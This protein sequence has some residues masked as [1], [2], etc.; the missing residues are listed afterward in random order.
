MTT[1]APSTLAVLIREEIANA[2]ERLAR[3]PWQDLRQHMRLVAAE[4]REVE[5]A[6]A[7][8]DR[9]REWTRETYVAVDDALRA[10]F[11]EEPR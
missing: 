9:H 3:S 6:L 8:R 7:A 5:P 1:L 4:L 11:G 2:L 10:V